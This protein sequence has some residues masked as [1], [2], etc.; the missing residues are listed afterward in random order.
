MLM[1]WYNR[2][3]NVGIV[4]LEWLLC[5]QSEDVIA[6]WKYNKM[7]LYNIVTTNLLWCYKLNENIQLVVVEVVYCVA[8]CV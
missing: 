5:R 7:W 8:V 1:V 4:W 3:W 2:K 6:V